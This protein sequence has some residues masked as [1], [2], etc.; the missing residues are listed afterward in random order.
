MPDRLFNVYV[1]EELLPVDKLLPLWEKTVSQDV[2]NHPAWLHEGAK[3]YAGAEKLCIRV[4]DTGKIIAYW[5]FQVREGG[6]KEAWA[7]II[8]PIGSN[9]SDYIGPLADK[10]Y[11]I[12][13]ILDLV[14]RELSRYLNIRTVLLL[15][16]T[17]FED[18]EIERLRGL[19][20]ESGGL[21]ELVEKVCPRMYFATTYDETIKVWPSRLR[22]DVRRQ[23]R[24]LGEQ[25]NLILQVYE[26][27]IADRLL[28]LAMMHEAEWEA[29]GMSSEFSN[30]GEL[31][32]YQ[33][34]AQSLPSDRIHYSEVLLE[35]DPI[36]CH[37]GFVSNGWFY[38][39]KPTYNMD[40]QRFS[41]GKVHLALL[42]Q[43]GIKK[44]LKGID[45]LQG[46][47]TYK[48][49]WANNGKRTSTLIVSSSSGTL[50]WLWQTKWRAQVRGTFLKAMMNV[51][52][53]LG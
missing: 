25:G 36:S 33:G 47:E 5:P 31:E 35:G 24:R 11:S 3:N 45:F 8:E 22:G 40:Y 30:P 39:Y 37:F 14:F 51:K 49:Q 48:D 41:P 50:F 12:G 34:V 6:V 9:K 21:F 19:V 23:M 1:D 16:K 15:P 7:R 18:A 28:V 38:W 32:F 44:G 29:K 13:I 26:G 10:D 42:S 20:T 53:R 27:S 46:A 17:I 52:G 43:W 2:F 4:M